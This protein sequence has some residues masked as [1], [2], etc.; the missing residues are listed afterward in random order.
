[1]SYFVIG[2]F[3]NQVEVDK[4]LL[5][6]ENA[7]YYDYSISDA[8][9]ESAEI[10]TVEKKNSLWN[11]LFESNYVDID[12]CEFASIDHN[13]ITVHLKTIRDVNIVKNIL[14]ERGASDFIKKTNDNL[15]VKSPDSEY[16]ITEMTNSRII[17]KAKNNLFFTNDR[18]PHW[19]HQKRI[20]DEI[21]GSGIARFQ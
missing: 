2:L 21:D 12:R 13:T 10:P 20:A 9:N 18:K 4:V 7:G 5:K 17:N 8:Q 14:D 6:L 1:M 16:Y 3:P 15:S 19:I 11:W